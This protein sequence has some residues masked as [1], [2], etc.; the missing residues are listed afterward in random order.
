MIKQFLKLSVLL[1]ALT[2]LLIACGESDDEEEM[3]VDADGFILK[4]DDN[5]IY[6]Q[7]QGT[8]TGGI[9]LKVGEELEV[10]TVFIDHDGHEITIGSEED[11][12]DHAEAEGDDH[13]AEEAYGLALSEYDSSIIEVH[14][15]E[16]EAHEDD[17]DDD[18]EHAEGFV[19]EVVGRRA[20]QTGI[21]LELLHGDHP[22]F[23]AALKI[24]V[25]VSP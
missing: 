4:V 13:D 6:R 21:K 25:T 7:F 5:E 17:H 9:N 20:G 2:T 11:D 18:E 16:G 8:E 19:F 1:L 14:L 10:V 22:D 24:P 3:H 15:P 12:H 23:T